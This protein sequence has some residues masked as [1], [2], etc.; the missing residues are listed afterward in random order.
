MS[1]VWA[2][3]WNERIQS[4][5]SAILAKGLRRTASWA[6]SRRQP[7]TVAA[8]L[9]LRHRFAVETNE[10]IATRSGHRAGVG[11]RWPKANI[12]SGS[13][14]APSRS[15]ASI[16]NRWLRA[17]ARPAA[18]TR[19]LPTCTGPP[20]D[21]CERSIL[22]RMD[23]ERWFAADPCALCTLSIAASDHRMTGRV[24]QSETDRV[25]LASDRNPSLTAMVATTARPAPGHGTAPA[26]AGEG[27][28]L[29]QDE[30]V[31]R[32]S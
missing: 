18:P 13:A 28:F 4:G 29:R 25:V 17:S 9:A 21:R 24:E 1:G 31:S 15:E 32:R 12:A 19:K 16:P 2:G 26:V 27:R 3:C 7:V 8:A 14:A 11:A 10:G 5:N 23:P 30:G 22:C 6:A 20:S